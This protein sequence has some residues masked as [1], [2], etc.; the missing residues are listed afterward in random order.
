MPP[1]R[2]RYS[3]RLRS[4]TSGAGT[5]AMEYS[6]HAAV[7]AALAKQLEAGGF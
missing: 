7:D 5:I 3:T 6:H 2:T 1:R 4:L